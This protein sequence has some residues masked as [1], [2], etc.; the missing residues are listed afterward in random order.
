MKR[1]QGKLSPKPNAV[2]IREEWLTLPTYEPAAPE[3]NP[4]FLERRVYEGSSGKVYPLPFTD[5]IA[6]Q[7]RPRKWKAIW[8][9]NKFLR[10]L[11]LPKIYG[12]L[13]REGVPPGELPRQFV[14]SHCKLRLR[15]PGR[16]RPPRESS[17]FACKSSGLGVTTSLAMRGTASSPTPRRTASLPPTWRSWPEDAL[18]RWFACIHRI[19]K[20]T[21]AS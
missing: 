15:S 11:V 20:N 17:H 19:L 18:V 16:H 8:I 5:R 7:P 14:P 1:H 21:S 12:Q 9:E 13:A 2:R 4:M 6:E 3:K 10:V